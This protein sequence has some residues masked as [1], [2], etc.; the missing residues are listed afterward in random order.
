VFGFRE[1]GRKPQAELLC[2]F[3]LYFVSDPENCF[4]FC[5]IKL[6]AL[7]RKKLLDLSGVLRNF[8]AVF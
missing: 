5:L 6:L 4:E 1:K 2:C 8:L 7:R 3:F